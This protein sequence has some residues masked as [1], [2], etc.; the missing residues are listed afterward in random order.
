MDFAGKS[1]HI[2]NE[3]RGAACVSV[4]FPKSRIAFGVTLSLLICPALE[5]FYGGARIMADLQGRT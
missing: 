4:R 5:N 1:I 3:D 2:I